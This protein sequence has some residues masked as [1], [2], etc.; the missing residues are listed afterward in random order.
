MFYVCLF[1][2]FVKRAAQFWFD[3]HG[4]VVLKP[5]SDGSPIRLRKQSSH[6]P[7]HLFSSKEALTREFYK[8]IQKSLF[9]EQKDVKM[10][11]LFCLYTGGISLKFVEQYNTALIGMLTE[12][13]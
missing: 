1:R 12:R 7:H 6:I 2:L 8:S 5:R 10:L 13:L 3:G 4:C 9:P 11:E